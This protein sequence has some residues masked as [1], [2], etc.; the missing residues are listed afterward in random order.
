M[1]EY[2]V[3]LPYSYVAQRF[4][5]EPIRA[6]RKTKKA[7]TITAEVE[8]KNRAVAKKPRK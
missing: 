1:N 8:T 2:A 6:S 7:T 5:E 3:H 4:Y